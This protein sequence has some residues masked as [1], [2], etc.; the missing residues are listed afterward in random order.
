MQS[1][2][3]TPDQVNFFH[4]NGYLVLEN[5]RTPQE[6][7]Q[8]RQ[9]IEHII[10]SQFDPQTH[11]SIFICEHEESGHIRDEYFLNSSDQ[12]SFFLENN[13][14]AVKQNGGKF[15]MNKIGHALADKDAVFR[16]FTFRDFVCDATTQLMNYE[17][18]TVVQSMYIFKP[19]FI[20][21]QVTPHRDGT[22]VLTHEK[23]CLGWWFP[24]EDATLTNGCLWGAPGSHRDGLATKWVRTCRDNSKNRMEFVQLI[25][26]KEQR[27]KFEENEKNAHYVPLEMKAG[28]VVIL[29]GHFLHKSNRNESSKSRE[30][31]TFHLADKKDYDMT[32]NWLLRDE[33]PSLWPHK[34]QQQ[35][36]E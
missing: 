2:P 19:P 29:H 10:E 11:K 24:L 25:S 33:F 34:Q 5:F 14:D 7:I 27:A 23:P 4:E 9:R 30:A 16:D 1:P 28:S 32:Q 13:A 22:F 26:D 8:L 3:L 12:I 36:Q 21:G 17:E 35:Q 18:P 6:T 31:Y 20:G 15:I